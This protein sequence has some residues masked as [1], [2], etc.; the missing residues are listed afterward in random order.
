M[1][2]VTV[3]KTKTSA[4]LRGFIR[5]TT[6]ARQNARRKREARRVYVAGDESINGK[7]DMESFALRIRFKP[8]FDE[9]ANCR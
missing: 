8:R 5:S 2:S 1:S 7:I 6:G 3:T 9:N 4:A